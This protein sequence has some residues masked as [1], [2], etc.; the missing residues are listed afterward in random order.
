LARSSTCRQERHPPN[1]TGNGGEAQAAQGIFS[2]EGGIKKEKNE[3]ERQKKEKEKERRKK[4]K[5]KGGRAR[6]APREKEENKYPLL[7]VRGFPIIAGLRLSPQTNIQS[8]VFFLE[9]MQW[10]PE[11]RSQLLRQGI[12]LA[13]P[14][15]PLPGCGPLLNQDRSLHQ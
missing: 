15:V 11:K 2:T 1:N 7:E 12:T 9:V 6:E 13:L 10:F 3:Q 8:V 14:Q 4:K 5:E